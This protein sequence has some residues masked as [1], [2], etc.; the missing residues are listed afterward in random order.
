MLEV[1]CHDS[2]YGVQECALISLRSMCAQQPI[3]QVSFEANVYYVLGKCG[4]VVHKRYLNTMPSG[5]YIVIR[6]IITS[7]LLCRN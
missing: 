6:N 3:R 5:T 4:A 7:F 2:Q 1:A